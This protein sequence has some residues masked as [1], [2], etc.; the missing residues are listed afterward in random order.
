[1]KQSLTP[2]FFQHWS[3][4]TKQKSANLDLRKLANFFRLLSRI[5]SLIL[6]F[7]NKKRES[8]TEIPEIL[9]ERS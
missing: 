6:E 8:S 9:L 7:D 3:T 4:N 1:M 2:L 5:I